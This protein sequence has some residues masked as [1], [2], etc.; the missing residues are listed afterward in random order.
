MKDQ[1]VLEVCCSNIE[2]VLAANKAKANRI[3]ICSGPYEGGITP[4]YGF[5]KYAKEHFQGEVMVLIRPREGDFYYLAEEFET[6]KEDIKVCKEL[7]V[8]GVTLGILQTNGYVDIKRTTELVSLASPMVVCFN[9]AFDMT[10]NYFEAWEDIVKCGCKRVLTSGGSSNAIGG[11]NNLDLL[12][13]RAGTSIEIIAAGGL[14][15]VNMSRI[16]KQTGLR[17]YHLSA[18][19]LKRSI[20]R[21]RNLKVSLGNFSEI[22][23]YS[24]EVSNADRIVR[25]KNALLNKMQA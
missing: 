2:S 9:R 6:M 19:Q 13:Q 1:F 4:S 24:Y 15:S 20:M 14:N 18:K 7:G 12:N 21:Y 10:I 8:A 5:I 25:A 22:P 23:E 16:F 17:Q 3:E 11:V